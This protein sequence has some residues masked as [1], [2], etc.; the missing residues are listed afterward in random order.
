MKKEK[1]TTKDEEQRRLETEI[2]GIFR[3]ICWDLEDGGAKSTWLR[4]EKQSFG[5][6]FER[7]EEG[8]NI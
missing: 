1:T 2:N 7:R 4:S 5:I 6:L 8:Q 3:R